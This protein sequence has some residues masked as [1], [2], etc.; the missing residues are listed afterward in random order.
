M[1]TQLIINIDEKGQINVTG[2]IE[3]KLLCYGILE[4]ARQAIQNY[5]PSPII[6]PVLNGNNNLAKA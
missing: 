1:Q 3:N 6:K 2:P 5:V 4:C